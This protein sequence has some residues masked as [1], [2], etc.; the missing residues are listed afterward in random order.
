MAFICFELITIY[1]TYFAS[2]SSAASE[3]KKKKRLRTII[4]SIKQ[5]TKRIEAS[6]FQLS[7][8]KPNQ[9]CQSSLSQKAHN[10]ANE[11]KLGVIILL[12]VAQA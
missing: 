11:S 8:L 6:G 5:Q 3:E 12:R 4:R 10:T 9:S 7:V 1:Q 2:F